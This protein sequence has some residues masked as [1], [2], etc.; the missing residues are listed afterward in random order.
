MCVHEAYFVEARSDTRQ[1][2]ACFQTTETLRNF[3]DAQVKVCRSARLMRSILPGRPQSSR[4]ALSTVNWDGLRVVVSALC[5][6][7]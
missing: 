4:Q 1:I 2:A 5:P 7:P 6:Y 3:L